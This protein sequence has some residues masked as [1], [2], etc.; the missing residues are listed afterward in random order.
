VPER[1]SN[2]I[3]LTKDEAKTLYQLLYRVLSGVEQSS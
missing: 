3:P 2:C 1:M